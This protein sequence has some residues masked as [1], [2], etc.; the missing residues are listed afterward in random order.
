VSKT[1]QLIDRS[2]IVDRENCERKRYLAF[3]FDLNG[4]TTRG[5]QRKEMS[6]PLL[7]GDELHIAHAR[8]LGGQDIDSVVKQIMTSYESRVKTRGIYGEANP[9]QLI[10]EQSNLLSAMLIAF[11]YVWLPRILDEYDVV[12]IEK[13]ERWEIA[14][15]LMVSFRFDTMLRRKSDGQLVTLDYKSMPYISEGWAQKMERSRQTSLYVAGAQELYGEPVEIAYLGTVKGTWRKDTARSS[16]FYEQKIQASPYLYAYTLKGGVG[17]VYQTAYTSKKGF[18]K[19]RTYEEMPI[20]EWMDWMWHNERDV[21]NEQFTFVPPFSQTPQEMARIRALVVH[22]ELEYLEN[23][24]RY[25]AMRDEALKT[26]NEALL[27]KAQEFLDLVAAPMR[28]EH[29]FIYGMENKCAFYNICHNEGAMENVMD[30]GEFEA[31]E[32]HHVTLQEAA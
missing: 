26:G 21:V 15:G 10:R 24:D 32:P 22:E 4:S 25:H 17:D 12:T 31:R 30:D 18:Q 29:C 23:I 11:A 8:V 14:P 27:A 28:D 5:I 3:D 1:I 2:R 16:P 6:L 20:R 7:N 19:V 9:T 13:P